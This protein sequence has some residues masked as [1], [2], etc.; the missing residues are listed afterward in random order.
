MRECCEV[1]LLTFFSDHRY[2]KRSKSYRLINHAQ[3]MQQ[4]FEHMNLM[5]R[6][7]SDK[8]ERQDTAIV[9][10]QRGQ[11]PITLNVRGNQG[12]DAMREEDGD[13]LDNFD[14]HAIVNMHG[15]YDK[16]QDI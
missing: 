10:L 14:D 8:L 5:F 16:K 7:I 4:Q 1:F 3:A 13:D 2:V 6:E 11:Q 12:R 15:R 9:N